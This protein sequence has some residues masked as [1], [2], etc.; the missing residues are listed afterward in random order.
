[1]PKVSRNTAS[2]IDDFGLAEDRH[3]DLDGYTVNFVT[4]RQSHDLA[5]MLKCLP[6]GKCQCP[7]WGYLLGGRM[8]VRYD[9]HEE[10]I[11]AG[12]AFYMPPGHAPEAEAG[13]Q[14]V[15]FS[16]AEKLAETVSALKAGM[17]SGAR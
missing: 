15:Q 1:M 13:T 10:V 9:N 2:Q 16:P 14:I 12:D 3:D 8:I 6:G 17:P 11:E 7:H 4:I 5:P